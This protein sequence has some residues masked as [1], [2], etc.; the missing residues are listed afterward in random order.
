MFA[1]LVLDNNKGFYN[2][3]Y[4]K[5]FKTLDEAQEYANHVVHDMGL[6]AKIFDY[7]VE[8]DVYYEFFDVE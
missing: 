8:D 1:V 4:F 3:N 7:D 5:I 6:K 2:N